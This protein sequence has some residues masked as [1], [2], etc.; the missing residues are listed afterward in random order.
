MDDSGRRLT[1]RMNLEDSMA[2]DNCGLK[3]Y[4]YSGP[5]NEW[6]G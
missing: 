2:E 5:R 4:K 1:L 3:E 6:K